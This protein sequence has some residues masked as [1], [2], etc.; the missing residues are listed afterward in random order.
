MKV[1]RKF[2]RQPK[3]YLH[4]FSPGEKLYIAM[5]LTDDLAKKMIPYGIVADGTRTI[6]V[7]IRAATMF[8]SDG[9][10]ILR[11]DLPKEVRI[12]EHEYHIVDWHG[13]DH[14]GICQQKR[15]CY[16][17][18]FVP[19]TKLAF[20]VE[21]G[22]IFSPCFSNDESNMSKIK[23]AMNIMLEI[24]GSFE[25]WT[26]SKQPALP[27]IKQQN[28]PWE[29]L[30]K[31]TLDRTYWN[32]YVDTIVK[33]RTEKQRTI[34]KHR[35]EH[36]WNMKPDFCVLGKENF[37]GYVVYGFS[38]QNIFFFESNQPD[39]ATYVFRGNWEEAS[40]LTKTEILAG[41]IQETRLFHT[42]KWYENI[43]A[44][45]ANL[46]RSVAS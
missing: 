43:R 7:P 26:D 42:E 11:K 39:N 19:P 18:E 46:S 14:Y 29:I 34:I 45:L 27:P 33:N 12:V 28:V 30:R 6:P 5:Q 13:N 4:A 35:H 40:K 36:L 24:F 17:R 1:S 23:T 32:N 20:M 38:N 21:N 2:V 3:S 9:R 22:V 10:W 15:M 37:W 41:H 44:T 16:Q 25:L 31:G 8:N